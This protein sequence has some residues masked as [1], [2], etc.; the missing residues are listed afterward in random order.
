MGTDGSSIDLASRKATILHALL[1]LGLIAL[2]IYY[3][4]RIVL[5]FTGILLWS[6][7]LA[8]MLYPLHLRLSA[9]WSNRWSATLIGVTGIAVML[10]P[11][12][13]V[14]TSLGSSI[15]SL[16]SD[17][18]NHTLTIPPLPPWVADLPLIGRKVSEIWAFIS[19]NVQLALVQYG[20]MLRRPIAWLLS[21]AGGL[22]LGGLSFIL[23]IGIAALLLA[24]AK[25]IAQFARRLLKF[26]AGSETRAL[27][28]VALTTATIRGVALGVVGVAV[29][30]TLLTGIAFFAIGL[31]AAGVLTFATLLLAI[32][33]I[34]TLLLTVPVMIYVFST[35]ATTPAIIFIVWTFI[36]GLSDNV[37]KPL[38]LGRGLEVPMPVILLGVIGGL[39]A[40]DLLGLF[41]GPVVLAVA[42]TL[43]VE[44]LNYGTVD[45]EA[46][47]EGQG[48]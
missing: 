7:I 15:Y 28:I 26:V 34:P 5:P 25:G 45:D 18:R 40:E 38:L 35:E 47:L 19:T 22:A 46:R 39:L 9:R 8:V 24:Y 11:M 13:L 12:I 48:S 16:V 17:L 23:S 29:I 20:E 3:C 36:A 37:L 32:V 2:L 10:V 44:W 1:Q 33:Q 43:L 14:V 42:Y 41:I 21:F 6:S 30:Q 4:S 27:H 31:P